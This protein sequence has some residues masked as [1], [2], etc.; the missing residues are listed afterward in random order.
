MYHGVNLDLDLDGGT[1]TIPAARYKTRKNQVFPLG[2]MQLD[3]LRNLP[4]WNEKFVFPRPSHVGVG[5]TKIEEP[6]EVRAVTKNHQIAVWTKVRNKPLGAHTF[7]KTL[8]TM[9]LNSGIPLEAVSLIL[10]HSNTQTTQRAYAELSPTT[11][12]KLLANFNG[13][14]ADD[15]VHI[16]A[17]DSKEESDEMIKALQF[18]ASRGRNQQRGD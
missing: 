11:V 12:S 14:T 3:F 17:G 18:Q 4:R 6:D 9:Y 16:R 2:P 10:G 5:K 7:R 1:W 13:L 15:E 8:G